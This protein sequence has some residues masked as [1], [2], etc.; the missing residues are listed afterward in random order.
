MIKPQRLAKKDKDMLQCDITN[1]SYHGLVIVSATYKF[2]ILFI[3]YGTAELI[4]YHNHVF[5]SGK[6]H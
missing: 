2:T 6:H 1:I 4:A 5:F 3:Y